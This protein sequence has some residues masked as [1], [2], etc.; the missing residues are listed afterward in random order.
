MKL[1][2]WKSGQRGT[3]A[4]E[5]A[6]A[7]PFL[8]FLLLA[9]GEVGRAI[10]QYNELTKA[11]RDAARY[12]ANHAAV[13][14]TDVIDID[15]ELDRTTRELLVYGK[16][17]AGTTPLLPGLDISDVTIVVVDDVHVR[18]DVDY[19]YAPTIGGVTMPM[20]GTGPTFDIAIP[21]RASVAMRAL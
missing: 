13:G 14:S 18:V 5:L 11:T 10:I 21:L 6:I 8:L 1:K 2:G 7:L 15:A 3:A 17:L 19:D 4:V 20:F 9:I 16:P 12:L